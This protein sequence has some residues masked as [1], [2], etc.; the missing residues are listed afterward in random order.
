MISKVIAEIAQEAVCFQNHCRRGYHQLRRLF[1]E[2]K[3]INFKLLFIGLILD[4]AFRFVKS[5]QLQFMNF[6]YFV[7]FWDDFY[8]SKHSADF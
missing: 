8:T 4:S 1:F 7:V 3:S 6:C 2:L 5:N